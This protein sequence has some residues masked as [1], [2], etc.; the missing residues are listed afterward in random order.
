MCILLSFEKFL[1]LYKFHQRL[2]IH[3]TLAVY[4]ELTYISFSFMIL[5]NQCVYDVSLVILRIVEVLLEYLQQTVLVVN[6][7]SMKHLTS[8]VSFCS[9]CHVFISLLQP[10]RCTILSS[11]CERCWD[12]IF[13]ISLQSVTR[14]PSY[15]WQLCNASAGV[16]QFIL[17]TARLSDM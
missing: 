13:S 9:L 17:R 10:A 2:R 14:K 12:F 11:F 15:R 1:H 6:I 5:L 16:V 4:C 7:L 3:T 8:L